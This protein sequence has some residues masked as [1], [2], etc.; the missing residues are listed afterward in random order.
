ME[1]A[2]SFLSLAAAA[3][4]GTSYSDAK[5]LF[6]D[7]DPHQVETKKA[8]FQEFGLLYV[9]PHS[10]RLSITPLGDQILALTIDRKTLETNRRLLLLALGRG[11]ARYQFDN[12]LPVGGNAARARW[13]STDVRPYLACYYLLHKLAGVLTVSELRGAV[14]GL[15]SMS[16]I[17][18]LEDKIRRQRKLGVMFE[19]LPGLPANTGTANNL[20]IYFAS[21]LSLSNS[22]MKTID[23]EKAYGGE[24]QAFELTQFGYEVTASVLD[25]EWPNWRS[26]ASPIPKAAHYGSVEEYFQKGV[27]DACPEALID[28]DSRKTEANIK[29]PIEGLLEKDVLE[30]I[31]ELPHRDYVEGRKRLVQHAKIERIRNQAL[32]KDAKRIFKKK[33]RLFCEVCTFDFENKYGKRGKDYIEAHHR[34][35]ISELDGTTT[36]RVTVADLAMVCSN[37]HRM[38]HRPPWIT[39]EELRALMEDINHRA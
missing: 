17:R 24:D 13:A 22:I 2:R 5:T 37:C 27:G 29:E 16:H 26:I 28:I 39:V 30:S 11:L 9:V 10:N 14:F 18:N 31:M 36:I 8:A 4:R 12:P 34:K 3:K 15:K 32:V 21:H 6:S 19:D 38:L 33:G 23:R 35:P 1:L 25:V 7:L 20:K